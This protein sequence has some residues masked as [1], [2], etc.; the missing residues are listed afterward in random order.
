M[1]GRE[2]FVNTRNLEHHFNNF[3]LKLFTYNFFIKFGCY[4]HKM[5]FTHVTSLKDL[6]NF[7]HSKKHKIL[8]TD[9]MDYIQQ[10]NQFSKG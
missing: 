5:V 9:F 8:T 3:F 7:D 4:F 1:A 6:F 10:K 2:K